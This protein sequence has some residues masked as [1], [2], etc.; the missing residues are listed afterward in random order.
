MEPNPIVPVGQILGLMSILN[1]SPE[2]SNIYDI[3]D[4]ID[5]EFGETISI[6]KAAEILELVDTPKQEVRFTD[7]GGK[8]VASDRVG[9]RNI[10]SE[11]VFKLRLFH[12]I[13]AP[14][15]ENPKRSKLTG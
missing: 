15:H 2:L 9:R 4:E 6:V 11:Q 14:L 1:D 7:L 12:I 10:F 3:P 5:K 8:F 13:I